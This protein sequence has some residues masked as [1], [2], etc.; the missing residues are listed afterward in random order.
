MISGP[1]ITFKSNSSDLVSFLVTAGTVHA[2]SEG[3]VRKHSEDVQAHNR[4]KSL[5][6][7]Q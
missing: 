6:V 5:Q 1:N 3:L 7:K 4:R 2:N